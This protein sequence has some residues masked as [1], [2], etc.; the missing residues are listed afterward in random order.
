MFG[1]RLTSRRP[2]PLDPDGHLAHRDPLP[3]YRPKAAA[4]RSTVGRPLVFLNAARACAR[5]VPGR[6][7]GQSPRNSPWR[8]SA[9]A[10]NRRERDRIRGSA[11]VEARASRCLTA[12]TD[13][14][15]VALN[16]IYRE[17]HMKQRIGIIGTGDVGKALAKGFLRH[18]HQVMIGSRSADK[19]AGIRSS[20]GQELA[21]GTFK[22]AAGFAEIV[23]LAVKGTAAR[24]AITSAGAELAGKVVIDTTNPIADA[25]PVNGVLQFFT[26]RNESLLEQ[27]QQ[28]APSARF[29]KAWNSVGS[30]HMDDPHFPGGKPTMFIC[31]ND[32]AAKGMVTAILGDFGWEA[33][34]MGAA[35]S[36]RAIEPLCQLW[37]IPGLRANQWNH[38][39]KL[40][41]G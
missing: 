2:S 27:L 37:C 35:E 26:G 4:V 9:V 25:P 12:V 22:E 32:Q 8:R 36:A 23:V 18:G 31:G 19:L 38:A 34:D 15:W 24:E 30:A 41:K 13:A 14:V 11:R 7:S 6:K 40:L 10:T 3:T 33:E 5:A 21:T 39:F 20:I 1:D 17:R 28:A 16:L 29:V